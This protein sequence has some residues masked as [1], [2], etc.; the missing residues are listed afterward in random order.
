LA[1]ALVP[2][3]GT[4]AAAATPDA[5]RN[6]RIA[7]VV[8]AG[9]YTDA[10]Q[11][12]FIV[13]PD[14]T[15]KRNLTR[16]PN[17]TEWSQLWSPNGRKLAF[18]ETASYAPESQICVMNADRS[19]RRTLTDGAYSYMGSWSPDGRRIAYTKAN[20][21]QDAIGRGTLE[22]YV[23]NADGRGNRRLTRNKGIDDESPAWSPDGQWILFTR[24]GAAH[25]VYVMRPDGSEQ[26]R[27]TH[28]GDSHASDWSPDGRR[29]VFKR[30]ARTADTTGSGLYVVDLDG[31]ST[32]RLTRGDNDY[33]ATWSPDSRWILFGRQSSPGGIYVVAPDGVARRRLTRS[34]NDLGPTWSPDSRKIAFNRASEIWIMNRDGKQKHKVTRRTGAA[35]HAGAAWGPT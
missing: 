12:V 9:D 22:I 10:R 35:R 19:A 2:L 13:K 15:G 25:D 23:M 33:E 21:A 8:R 14:G 6:G 30:A 31:T 28:T 5:A 20:G 4:A 24:S 1:V 7:F 27:V 18:N 26:R 34:L 16:T 3:V 32:V 29:I 17:L 11:D